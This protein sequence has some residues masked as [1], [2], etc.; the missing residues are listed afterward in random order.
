MQNSTRCALASR[1]FVVAAV[2]IL[3]EAPAHGAASDQAVLAPEKV[4]VLLTQQGSVLPVSLKAPYFVFDNAEVGGAAPANITGELSAG[5][6]VEVTYAPILIAESASLEIKL[7]LEWSPREQVLRKWAKLRLIGDEPLLLKE[8]VLDKIDLGSRE[9]LPASVQPVI[10][11]PQSY[12]VFLRGFFAGIEFPIAATRVE[13]NCLIL[14]HRPGRR[15]EGG[16]SYETRKAVFGLAPPGSERATFERY[17]DAH[18]LSPR[19]F[20]VNYNHWWSTPV[21][22]AEPDVLGLAADLDRELFRPHGVAPDS[23][24][25]DVGWQNPQSVWEMDARNFPRG[26]DAI[27]TE[28]AK[29]KAGL[30]IWIS[31]SS[32][33][34][35]AHDTAWS[36][37]H[38]YETSAVARDGHPAPMP[39]A[40]L[41]GRRYAAKLRERLVDMIRRYD[42]VSV[43]LD[44][45]IFQC[46]DPNHGHEPGELSAEAIA[47][48]MIG[49][50]QGARE[51]SGD[52][53]LRPTCFGWN[54]SPWWL[55]YVN[56]VIGSFG[57][58]APY[59][60]VPAPVYRESYTSARDY[61]NLQGAALSP[62]PISASEVLGIVHQ[63]PDPFLNDGVMT[64]LRGHA[65]VPM[66][67]NPRYMNR[68]RWASLAGLLA[69]GRSNAPLLRRTVPL[70]PVSWQ[71]SGPPRFSDA[72]SMPREPYGYAHWDG[73]RGLVALRNPWIAPQ[74]YSLRLGLGTD[75]QAGEQE[76]VSVVSL[77]PAVRV[78]TAN[79]RLG[80]TLQVAL[81]PYETLVLSVG[82]RQPTDGLPQAEDVLTGSVRAVKMQHHLIAEKYAASPAPFGPDWT[83]PLGELTSAISLELQG[84]VEVRSAEAELLVLLEGPRSPA[85]PVCNLH[86][87]GKPT[88]TD[89]MVSDVGWAAT[90]LPQPEHWTFVRARLPHGK[91][92]VHLS[93]LTETSATA[94]SAWVRAFAPPDQN[95]VYPN[96][97]PSPEQVSLD[98]VAL[99]GPIEVGGIPWR[100]APVSRGIERIP[101]LYLDSMEP[102]SVVQG[103]G[104]LQKN[105][106]VWGKP[107]VIA[108]KSYL[109]GLGTSSQTKITYAIGG[110]YRRFQSWVG[111]DQA[112]NPSVTF[113]VWTDGEKRWESGLMKRDDPAKWCDVDVSGADVLELRVG[114]GDDGISAD[115]ADWADARLLR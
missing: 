33:Y 112:T 8:V 89:T 104:T 21:R 67:L 36:K 26:F 97:L 66:Y 85:V 96:A 16:N 78:Y 56:S 30:G 41:G 45:Y 74:S 10:Q 2:A 46:D 72:D 24:C 14:A 51:A 23:F 19:D 108:G 115:H 28:V 32:V 6:S 7:L 34:P 81:A 4:A 57:D 77:Y 49:V 12:P 73:S 13:N 84:D 44:G 64:V 92:A 107:L 40:C 82:P 100:P 101:G 103:W 43:K 20:T 54:P 87:D 88:S 37:A 114:D 109:R 60:R 27:R 9:V 69:W 31:P 18:R 38:G 80:E 48:G 35:Q 106:S 93:L 52:V 1:L 11:A 3:P 62:L 98:S 58:D 95:R 29:M 50:L 39:Y 61:Y 42:L 17:I 99:L 111:A 105:R 91:S 47:E 113:E 90:V 75:D 70:L 65:F 83:S 5:K 76:R 79:G 68:A 59:G 86:V 71:C 63:T 22:A 55:F 94:V 110:Q 102:S 25:I 15:L 53:W